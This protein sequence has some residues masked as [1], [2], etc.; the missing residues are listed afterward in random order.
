MSIEAFNKTATEDE[1]DGGSSRDEV[2]SSS[3]H[4]PYQRMLHRLQVKAL[5]NSR[6]HQPSS[7]RPSS[8]SS[9]SSSSSANSSSA[10]DLSDDATLA[11]ILRELSIHIITRARRA[12]FEIRDLHQKVNAAGANASLVRTEFMKCTNTIFVEQIV[13]DDYD[14]DKIID[15]GESKL[16]NNNNNN[17]NNRDILA[18]GEAARRLNQN[19]DV[20]LL[21][22]DDDDDDDDSSADIARL[23][24]EEKMAISDGMKALTLFFDPKRPINDNIGDNCGNN[25]DG[26]GNNTKRVSPMIM[27]NA[28]EEEEEE[29][30]NCYYYPS[31]EEDMFNQ[32]PL[33]F[34]IGS[35]EFMESSCVGL[36]DENYK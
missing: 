17:N 27:N 25:N 12:A 23:E 24:E 6:Q 32:R 7:C 34:I 3:H 28:S 29:D 9:S 14:D 13:T 10:W 31:A 15:N 21:S 35:R 16:G 8:S 26:N 2:S 36:G 18:H 4:Y 5:N 30:N 1:D 20:G 33:P 22:D 19:D 11:T